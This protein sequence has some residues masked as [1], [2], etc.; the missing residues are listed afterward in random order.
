MS[1]CLFLIRNIY[2]IDSLR[3]DL[4]SFVNVVN[5]GIDFHPFDEMLL[6]EHQIS[7]QTWD[8]VFELCDSFKYPGSCDL[9]LYPEGYP[10]NGREH[11][12]SFEERMMTIQQVAE[13]ALKHCDEV[14]LF[15]SD[16]NPYLPSFVNLNTPCQDVAKTLCLQ[17]MQYSEC[18]YPFDIPS[19]HMK[20]HRTQ[21]RLTIKSQARN[22][23][24]GSLCCEK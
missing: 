16:D 22:T 4:V 10:T 15:L 18:H 9:V 14:E 23:G 3:R 11:H 6:T 19:I 17:Y 5:F 1:T 20:I 12:L 8:F 7:L 13:I 24:D 2:I 21:D